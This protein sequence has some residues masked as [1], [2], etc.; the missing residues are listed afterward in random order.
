MRKLIIVNVTIHFY[1][2]VVAD[3]CL[4]VV[5]IVNNTVVLFTPVVAFQN[6]VPLTSFVTRSIIGFNPKLGF[7]INHRS[8]ATWVVS[9]PFVPNVLRYRVA[10]TPSTGK[11]EG[12]LLTAQTGE[13]HYRIG[14]ILV[15]VPTCVYIKLKGKNRF[16]ISG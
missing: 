8:S 11:G 5:G 1:A 15:D 16:R 13:Q 9:V 3:T 6:E 4:S 7:N 12:L 14:I 2:I 10:L